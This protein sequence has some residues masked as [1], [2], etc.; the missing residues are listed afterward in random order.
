MHTTPCA[1]LKR[2]KI[3]AKK[4][5]RATLER[6]AAQLGKV[7]RYEYG[8]VPFKS[9]TVQMQWKLC[10]ADRSSRN[11][12]GVKAMRELEEVI[13]HAMILRGLA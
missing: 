7:I 5:S 10:D 2:V 3:V 4:T 6:R 1:T 12:S 11:D 8:P 9:N 13:D